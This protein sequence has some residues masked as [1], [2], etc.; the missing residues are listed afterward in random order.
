MPTNFQSYRP[1]H[2]NRNFYQNRRSFSRSSTYTNKH[3]I[4]P[5][6]LV[7]LIIGFTI[8]IVLIS[9][10][11]I[12]LRG[13]GEITIVNESDVNYSLISPNDLARVKKALFPVLNI[14]NDADANHINV[15]VRWD[16]VAKNTQDSDLTTFLIDVDDFQQTYLVA[17]DSYNVTLDCPSPQLSKYPT[18]FCIGSSDENSDSISS[19]FGDELPLTAQTSQ[20]ETYI[21]TRANPTGGEWNHALA[22]WIFSC[23]SSDELTNRVSASLDQIIASRGAQASIFTK[24]YYNMSCNTSE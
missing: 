24:N 10:L 12:I 5:H 17:L 21:I 20:G 4:S 2:L 16:T 15:F 13:N 23:P 22:I 18:S 19:V 9:I 7:I 11:G 14:V 1:P 3:I 6:L 8:I